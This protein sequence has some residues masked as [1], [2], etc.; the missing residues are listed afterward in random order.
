MPFSATEFD[1][2]I[3]LYFRLI[4]HESIVDI[5]PGKGKYGRMLRRVQPRTKLIGIELDAGDVE[6]YKLR[7]LYDEVWVSDAADLMND[8][9][10]TFD[11]VIIG[12][13]IEHMR[14]ASGL[15][16]SISLS[17]ARNLSP[18]NFL[19]KYPRTHGRA[20]KVKP[21]SLSGPNMTS[22]AWTISSPSAI[23]SAWPG[24]AV[25]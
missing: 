20:I 19:C 15:I 24:F 9:D 12:D 13:C 16:C 25:T 3:E 2:E 8:P 5:G 22:A 21:I 1:S 4:R 11:A 17:I 7:E 6:Q 18:S 10:R 23:L 14:K